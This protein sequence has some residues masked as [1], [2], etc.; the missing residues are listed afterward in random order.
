MYARIFTVGLG[1]M[2]IYC[3]FHILLLASRAE[4]QK[5]AGW[6]LASLTLTTPLFILHFP[7]ARSD[8]VASSIC[9]IFV[10][11]ICQSRFKEW[12]FAAG[13]ALVLLITPKSLDLVGVLAAF[14]LFSSSASESSQSFARRAIWLLAPIAAIF[15]ATLAFNR[16]PIVAALIYGIDSYQQSPFNSYEHWL[17]LTSSVKSAL[18]PSAALIIG[19]ILSVLTFISAKRRR[20]LSHIE[21]SFIVSGLIVLIFGLLHSQKYLFFLASRLPFV[22]LLGTPGWIR[23]LEPYFIRISPG[24]LTLIGIIMILPNFFISI[25]KYERHQLFGLGDQALAHRELSRF[26]TESHAT[27]FWD[28]IGMFP[29]RNKIFHYPSPGDRKNE[30]MISF[31]ESSKPSLVIRTP[32]MNLLEPFLFVWLQKNYVPI[33]ADVYIRVGR[34]STHAAAPDCLISSDSIIAS[35]KNVG[36][37]DPNLIILIKRVS[38]TG[39]NQV[40]FRSPEGDEQ[41]E[42]SQTTLSQNFNFTSCGEDGIRYV[43]AEA[44]PWR[45]RPVIYS[46]SLFGYYGRL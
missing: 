7:K 13:A 2:A 41:A 30:D 9:L 28:G 16:S 38:D 18:L 20:H 15:A 26:I 39:W 45:A 33:S 17:H 29:K 44:G 43:V 22:L 5:S 3:L 14:F 1:A 4:G 12:F 6:M 25:G 46:S 21:K 37:R 35:A 34:L 36:L 24:R 40:P 11:L 31:V 19:S 32:K 42:L 27:F 10:F 8:T 23:F